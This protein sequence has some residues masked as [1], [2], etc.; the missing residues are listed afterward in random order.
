MTSDRLRWVG[1]SPSDLR[2]P[3]VGRGHELRVLEDALARVRES[4]Q[5]EIVTVLGPSGIGKSRLVY[6]FFARIDTPDEGEGLRVYRGS[7]RGSAAAYAVF[8]KILRSR[9]G[10]VD[11]MDADASKA[12]VRAQVASLL[13]D[14]KVGDVLFFLGQLLGI[15]FPDSPLT[16]AVGEDA[17]EAR[18]VRRTVLRALIEA[19]AAASP[20]A[21]F[22]DDLDAA[23]EDSLELLSF[24]LANLTGPI[25]IVCA[26]RNDLLSRR[27]R[28]IM[29]IALS[30]SP[31]RRY[32]DLGLIS[33]VILTLFIRYSE[34]ASI[35]GISLSSEGLLPG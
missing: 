26:A 23:H 21:F 9:F 31:E 33:S 34:Y 24:L 13:E 15:P 16:K 29:R 18:L 1:L 25:L 2:A 3:L 27:E 8:E 14:R 17:V 32:I 12:L 5:T 35:S 4:R 10:L 30:R 11:G 19:D 28:F 6:E 22:F 7:A 20:L